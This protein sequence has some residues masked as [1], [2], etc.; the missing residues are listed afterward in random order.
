[1]SLC[2]Y[3]YYEQ[4]TIPHSILRI[5]KSIITKSNMVTSNEKIERSL[6]NSILNKW[7]ANCG[8]VRHID[9]NTENNSVSNLQWV[10]L[11]QAMEHVDDWTVDWTIGLTAEE[12]S[13][14]KTSKWRNGL[15]FT[16]KTT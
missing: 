1:M 10:T 7:N 8:F 13:L 4:F 16:P 15:Q 12:I 3:H 2:N 11:P 9:G 5:R 6:T 14:V